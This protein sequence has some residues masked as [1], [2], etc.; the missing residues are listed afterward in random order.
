M[1]PV[2]LSDGLCATLSPET[3]ETTFFYPGP[4][5]PEQRPAA[6]AQAAWDKAKEFCIECPVFVRC[7]AQCWGMDYGVI[8]GTDQRER[9]YE[10][11][12]IARRLA[13]R[14]A[15]ERAQLAAYIHARHAGGLGDS[16]AVIARTTGYA[17]HTVNDLI[18]EHQAVLDAQRRERPAPRA[19]ARMEPPALVFPGANP[20]KADGWVWYMGRAH[21]GHYVAETADGAYVRMKIKPVRAQTTKWLPVS[22][23]DL[24]TAVTPAVQDWVGRPDGVQEIAQDDQ[25]PGI[26]AAPAA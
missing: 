5:D 12:R 2:D 1:M 7:R 14:E 4:A 20:P 19:Q 11:R 18:K 17:T 16:P 3:L 15:D 24:R 6:Y 21:A 10:R 23:V 26:E 8:G 13:S 25:R 9:H 22:H